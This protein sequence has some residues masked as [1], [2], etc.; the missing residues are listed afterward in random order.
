[1][2]GKRFH[3]FLGG[4][5]YELNRQF[6]TYFNLLFRIVR[7]GI[8]RGASL[9]DLGQTAEIPKTRLGGEVVEKYI[10]G[11]HP[12]WLVRKLLG[13]GKGILEYS[14]VV[15]KTHVFKEAP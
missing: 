8:E 3:F 10:L 2:Y 11:H 6:N 4:I 9:I 14:L 7:E 13:A 1:M 12:N 5:D 15:P